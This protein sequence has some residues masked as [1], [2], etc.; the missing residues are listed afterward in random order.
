MV[1][2]Q[3]MGTRGYGITAVLGDGAEQVVDVNTQGQWV[4]L[5]GRRVTFEE[6]VQAK[7][8]EWRP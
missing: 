3:Q 7:P 4:T 1:N 8:A 2:G 6:Y 5:N